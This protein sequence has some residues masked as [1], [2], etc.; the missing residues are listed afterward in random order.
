M[1]NVIAIKKSGVECEFFKRQT[2]GEEERGGISTPADCDSV[3]IAQM[4]ITQIK[5]YINHMEHVLFNQRFNLDVIVLKGLLKV[6][7]Y[8]EN[9]NNFLYFFPNL[10]CF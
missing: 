1:V 10:R 6:D 8:N 7:I 5:Q 9:H 3:A 4:Q 2:S